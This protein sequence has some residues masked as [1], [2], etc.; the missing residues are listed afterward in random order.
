M[1][2]DAA[3]L[4]M[5]ALSLPMEARV[6]LI[7]SLLESLD[8]EVDEDAEVRWRDEIVRRLQEIDSGNVKVVSW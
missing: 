6:A 7:D 3:E 8:T 4:L 1:A 5:D 2:K